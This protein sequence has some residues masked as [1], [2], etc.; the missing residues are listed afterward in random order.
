MK[1]VLSILTLSLLVTSA[2]TLESC[3]RGEGDPFISLLSRKARIT[4]HWKVTSGK[5]KDV[6]GNSVTNW[7]YDGTT[8]VY[9]GASTGSMTFTQEYTFE[10][11][12]TFKWVN[13]NPNSMVSEVDTYTGTW[14]FTAG[15]GDQKNKS[16]ILL[17]ILTYNDGVSSTTFTGSD[18][19]TLLY[20]LYQLKNKEIIFK[21]T[22]TTVDNTGISTS[23]EFEWV[24][25]R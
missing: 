24:L 17:T 5:G 11:D 23:E 1:K 7:T 10:K 4:G 20:D 14:N 8:Q 18:A 19:P 25:T 22:G 21:G 15:I 12:G 3:K 2:A 9:T 13:S 6:I 16:Q